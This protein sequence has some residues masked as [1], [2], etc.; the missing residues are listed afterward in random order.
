MVTVNVAMVELF[1]WKS[2]MS[3]AAPGAKA[4]AARFLS[5]AFSHAG[6]SRVA[7]IRTR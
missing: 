3:N 4:V 7:R 1:K 2:S 5:L 6:E